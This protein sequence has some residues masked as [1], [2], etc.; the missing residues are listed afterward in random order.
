MP[1][2]PEIVGESQDV[3]PGLDE[4][5]PAEGG[6]ETPH[7]RPVFRDVRT[8]SGITRSPL[9]MRLTDFS[10]EGERAPPA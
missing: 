2:M 6:P 10:G 4:N 1:R 7:P 3:A 9:V 8:E 5:R